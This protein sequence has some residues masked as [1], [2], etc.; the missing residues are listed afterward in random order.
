M[1]CLVVSMF[2]AI[3]LSACQTPNLVINEIE[4]KTVIFDDMP[5]SAASNLNSALMN[6]KWSLKAAVNKQ[7]QKMDT[8]ISLKKP[9]KL[10]FSAGVASF[11]VGCNSMNAHYQLNNRT[12]TTGMIRSTQMYCADLNAAEQTLSSLMAGDS[13]LAV[14]GNQLMQTTANGSTL[15]WQGELTDQ[16]KY[17]E[18]ETLF[19][20]VAPQIQSCYSGIN[21]QCLKV[22]EVYY[23]DNS[24]KSG[25][26]EWRL[27]DKSIKGYRH[28]P[29][30]R[31]LLRVKKYVT[32]PV[33]V[34]GK[35]LV[36]VLDMVVETEVAK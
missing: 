5:T 33:D 29:E 3:S 23:D 18:G 11:D 15:T 30:Y 31:K 6:H 16:A 7:N 32:D 28:D 19:L 1:K 34:K 8:L 35:Q 27:F 22:R 26:G 36:Y 13:Q 17:G 14:N 9:A 24:L 10:S 20:E 2:V 4:Q 21:N 25:Y 12:L